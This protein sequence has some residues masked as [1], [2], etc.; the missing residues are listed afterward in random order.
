[1]SFSG[2]SLFLDKNRSHLSSSISGR[3][4]N[5]GALHGSEVPPYYLGVCQLSTLLSSN[6]LTF[7]LSLN[8]GA[9]AIAVIASCTLQR[10]L[11]SSRELPDLIYSDVFCTGLVSAGIAMSEPFVQFAMHML[12][13]LL[14]FLPTIAS[15]ILL[16]RLTNEA[17]EVVLAE[18]SLRA[19]NAFSGL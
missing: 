6:S 9:A 5:L 4:T 14:S 8:F 10:F 2:H 3:L 1:M 19:C 11:F 7:W 16:G 17:E 18:H 13:R 12:S 15:S